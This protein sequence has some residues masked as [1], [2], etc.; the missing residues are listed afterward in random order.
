MDQPHSERLSRRDRLKGLPF[1]RMI[2]NILTLLALCAG[3][4]AIRY[5][6]QERWEHAGL[7]LLV[8]AILDG[9]DG[10]I[11]RVL[12]GASKFGA[13]LDSLSDFICFGVAPSLLL[14]MWTLSGAGR[15]G[16]V[17]A[18]LFSVCCV[19]RLA[20][21]NT[22][23]DETD[24]PAWTSNFFAGVPAPAGGGLVMLPMFL[25]FHFGEG[26]FK[27]PAM[28]AV[29]VVVVSALMVSRIPTFAFK[30][31]RVAPRWILPTMLLVGL[32]AALLVSAPWLT[33]ATT[34]I[35][36]LASIP[37]SLRSY[38]KFEQADTDGPDTTPPDATEEAP[39]PK[40]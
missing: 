36:Y 37:F 31:F 9:L 32:F 4:T 16:W 5:G 27:Q 17:L 6:L 3:M 35:L 38:R 13:E 12:K 24:Q 29:F 7:A 25:S 28:V 20:R 39:T 11:A 22:N 1:N 26:L 40:A 34:L 30:K 33:M 14:Y 23:L 10:R 15:I 19:L 8:A 21:F 2:P 18:L